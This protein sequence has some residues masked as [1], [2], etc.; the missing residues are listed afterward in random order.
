MKKIFLFSIILIIVVILI[1]IKIITDLIKIKPPN[2]SEYNT[3]FKSEYSNSKWTK[4][5]IMWRY[6]E[7]VITLPNGTVE[8]VYPLTKPIINIFQKA[9][10]IWNK[11]IDSISLIQTNSDDKKADITIGIS[12]KIKTS[13][14]WNFKIKKMGSGKVIKRAV[15]RINKKY[16]KDINSY[17]G[18]LTI[19]LH[20]IGNVL[21]LGDIKPSKR[22]KS[23]LEDPLPVKFD[24]NEL[25]D[26]DKQL[27]KQVYDD[28]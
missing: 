21:G 12:D 20:E 8:K 13:G 7:D 19:T 26:F 18:L 6:V 14:Y 4:P 3:F 9:F 1:I 17:K 10:S 15:I 2:L 16:L 27:I 11:S 25:W 23:I 22:L 28:I 24:E 5:N